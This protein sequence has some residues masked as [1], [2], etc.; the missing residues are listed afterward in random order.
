MAAFNFPSCKK[1]KKKK[2]VTFPVRKE[3]LL[4]FPEFGLGLYLG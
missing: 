1:K 4:P 3:S 2:Q